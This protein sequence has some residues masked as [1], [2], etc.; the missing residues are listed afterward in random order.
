MDDF[1]KAMLYQYPEKI[2]VRM[3]LLPGTWMKYRGELNAL[4]KKYPDIIKQYVRD[5]SNYDELPIKYQKGQWT[6][7]WGCVWSNL[8]DGL[9]AYVTDH[10]YPTRESVRGIKAPERDIGTPHGFMY[11]RLADLRGFEELMIDFAEEPLELEMLIQVVLEYNVRQVENMVR[12]N[13]DEI[14]WFG[15]DLGI[16]HGLAMGAE[17]WRKY[18][19]PCF[20]RLYGICHREGRYV[21]MHTD[22]CIHEIIP[23]LIDCGVN[24]VNAQF[25]AN[26]L[27]NLMRVCKDKICLDL[28]L[29]RQMF[30]F[31]TPQDIDDHVKEVVEKL[32][33]PRGGLSLIAECAPDVP[34]GNI[35][36]IC[37]AMEKYKNYWQRK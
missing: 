29:D 22:G 28:D 36:A 14:L 7:E 31:C 8:N 9:S 6:D 11:L 17:K 21:H 12:N 32:G 19:K 10:P 26:G 18:I 2:P 33:S 3:S 13:K 30:P 1:M 15:D 27:D 25:R 23:D 35:E 34:L 5:E 37:Q 24:S 16:Q 4:A 20:S